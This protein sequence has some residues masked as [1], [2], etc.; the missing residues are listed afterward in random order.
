[1]V[2]VRKDLR[3]YLPFASFVVFL[4][5]VGSLV[6]VLL[7]RAPD[8]VNLWHT[9][10][11]DPGRDA[12]GFLLAFGLGLTMLVSE[13]DRGTIA[14][15]DTLPA[16]RSLVFV[17]KVA[18]G[19]MLLLA[20]PLSDFAWRLPVLWLGRTSLDS[21]LH[22][23]FVAVTGALLYAAVAYSF[24]IGLAFSIA[25]R[26]A[27]AMG[28]LSLIFVLELERS[29][30]TAG[31]LEPG[32]LTNLSVQGIAPLIPWKALEAQGSLALGALMLAWVSFVWAADAA[33]RT[34]QD[35][36][37]SRRGRASLV[38]AT[39]LMGATTFWAF[40]VVMERSGGGHRRKSASASGLAGL[41]FAEERVALIRTDSYV[42]QVRG[43]LSQTAR[44]DIARADSL[45]AEVKRLFGNPTLEAIVVDATAPMGIAQH[46]GQTDWQYVSMDSR[47]L[48]SGS[49]AA[50]LVHETAHVY[51]NT[52]SDRRLSEH[53]G[54]SRAFSEGFATV[55]AED[56]VH[57]PPGW[58]LPVAFGRQRDLLRSAMLF[59]DRAL[60]AQLDPALAYGLGRELVRA[61]A[62]VGGPGAPV[63]VLRALKD[64]P[65]GID[66]I[67][68]WRDAYQ[69]AG[70]NLDNVLDRFWRRLEEA[71]A[72]EHQRL[73]TIP[74]TFAVVDVV[75][76]QVVVSV[77]P[78]GPPPPD[79]VAL[80]RIRPE[81]LAPPEHMVTLVAG[82]DG[83]CRFP[84]SALPLPKAGVTVG[85]A[86][87]DATVFEPWTEADV[88]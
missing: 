49:F 75:Q 35:L 25:R 17:A 40:A 22:G 52:V 71:K 18:A 43:A 29:F 34:F 69:R 20:F 64:V 6:D 3:G 50:V 73:A 87:A 74:R 12:V 76:E 81:P 67:T 31:L 9:L 32:S 78:D 63:G 19:F 80:C 68:L 77:M 60:R 59:D 24:L 65:K 28:A 23:G 37:H 70:L 56:L 44:G 5:W 1:V 86:F 88:R 54:S 16:T 13:H 62:D 2:L 57:E 10:H 79:A 11:D 39:L 47:V 8:Q 84:G 7:E 72:E 36:P 26:L 61:T 45:Q 30:P 42:F 82:S 83:K 55:V 46:L 51:A 38:A 14:F 21:G 27:W 58:R 41:S 4:F 85:W 48:G 53:F 66:G 15:L 33:A